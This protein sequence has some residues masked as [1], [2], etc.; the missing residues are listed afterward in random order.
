MEVRPAVLGLPDS[1]TVQARL[2]AIAEFQQLVRSTLIENYDYGT[3]PGTPRPTLYKPGAEKIIQLL[4]FADTYEI[5]DKTEDW[6]RP[7]F[8]YTVRCT[9]RS[10][11][12]GELVSQGI[13]ECNSFESRYRYRNAKRV[14]PECGKEAIIKGKAEYGGG[15]LCFKK[16]DGCGALFKDGNSAIEDQ[17]VGRVNNDDICDQVNTLL[18]MAKKRAMVDAALIAGRLSDLFTQDIED[19]GAFSVRFE[20]PQPEPVAA[21]AA[22]TAMAARPGPARAVQHEPVQPARAES[23]VEVDA[24][25]EAGAD[26][27][28]RFASKGEMLTAALKRWKKD[29]SAV[30]TAL[31]VDTVAKLN[32]KRLD[33]YWVRLEEAWG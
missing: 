9:L 13:G 5:V 17:A 18:K 25:R 16:N 1:Q 31:G 6:D 24:A 21:Q 33:D 27:K 7:L 29:S 22:S 15:W 23:P 4:G 32:I 19:F 12:T 11:E 8:A 14:C 30:C 20:N 3:I 26:A 10:M 28:P 2:T